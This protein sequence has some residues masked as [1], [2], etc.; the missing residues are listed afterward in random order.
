MTA[1]PLQQLQ[2]LSPRAR[3]ILLAAIRRADAEG[4]VGAT[5]AELGRMAGLHRNSVTMA[6][7]ELTACGILRTVSRTRGLCIILDVDFAATVQM[8]PTSAPTVKPTKDREWRQLRAR[9]GGLERAL[10]EAQQQREV[11]MRKVDEVLA[12]GRH[13]VAL[14]EEQGIST[15]VEIEI[16]AMRKDLVHAADCGDPDCERCLAILDRLEDGRARYVTEEEL[17]E[18][19][20]Q[21]D[22]LRTCARAIVEAVRDRG[23][24]SRARFADGLRALALALDGKH[25][26]ALS[27]VRE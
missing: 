22:A 26:D 15:T 9:A 4:T 1:S 6:M 21:A 11:A 16:A 20:R 3:S 25:E 14:R 2:A 17:A 24:G 27:L 12:R 23:V 13:R 5:V 10:R 7:R 18:R 19:L 8:S